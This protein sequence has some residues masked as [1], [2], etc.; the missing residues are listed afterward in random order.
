MG[1]PPRFWFKWQR[2]KSALRDAFGKQEQSYESANRMCPHC[3]AFITTSDRVCPYCNE[4]VGPRTGVRDSPSFL[5]GFVPHA[6]FVT[7]M[8][9]L[10]NFSLYAATTLYS[11]RSGN[12]GA[13]MGIDGRTLRRRTEAD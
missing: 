13:L 9:L 2:I 12:E 7:V 4:K 11:M 6:H 5:G 1:L 10:V 8:I 3:R